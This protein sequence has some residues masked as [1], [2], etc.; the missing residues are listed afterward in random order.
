[1]KKVIQLFGLALL[2]C[3]AGLHAQDFQKYKEMEGVTSVNIN[4]NLFKLM[5]QMDLETEDKEAQE[6]INMINQLEHI[7]IYTTSNSNAIA[8]LN[9]DAEKYMKGNNL[10]ELMNINDESGKRVRFYFKPGKSDEFV[11]QLFMHIVEED[12]TVVIMIEGNVNL[13]QVGKLAKEFN[14][15]GS[16]EFDKLEKSN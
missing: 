2:L 6:M 14:L 11:K 7:Q 15:P 9:R 8:S 10:E 1:M 16:T 5:S 13:A 3:S 12:E 4:K